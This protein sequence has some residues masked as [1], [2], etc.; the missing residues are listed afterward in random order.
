LKEFPNVTVE[1]NVKPPRTGAYEITTDDGTVLW[2]KLG[3]A[4]F[5][6]DQII[7]SKLKEINPKKS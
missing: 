5:P 1:G 7:L 4:G 6:D 2:S 3:G